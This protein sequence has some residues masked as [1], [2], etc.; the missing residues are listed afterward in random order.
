MVAAPWV[1]S[2]LLP[3]RFAPA[4]LGLP[5]LSMVY[6]F[7]A[8]SLILTVEGDAPTGIAEIW[9]RTISASIV[10]VLSLLFLALLPIATAISDMTARTPTIRTTIA[11]IN[12]MSDIP[13]SLFVNFLGGFISYPCQI[14]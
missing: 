14:Q 2:M 12:S 13:F 10:P 4:P 1:K 8:Q 7:V 11:I 6:E 3:L 9:S 5:A